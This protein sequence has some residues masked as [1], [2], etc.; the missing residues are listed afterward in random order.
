VAYGLRSVIVDAAHYVLGSRQHGDVITVEDA[1]ACPRK[2]SSFVWLLL[3]EPSHEQLAEL[4]ERFGLH[5]LAVED[6]Q[7]PHERP[8]LEQYDDF[9]YLVFCTARFDRDARDVQF[10][11]VH[12]FVAPGYVIEIRHGCATEGAKARRRLEQRPQLLKSGPAAAVWGILDE[13]VD[14]YAPVVD[15]LEAD[16]ATI[17]HQVFSGTEDPTEHIYL[18]TQEVSDFYRI[19]HPLLAPL[20]GLERG[21][22]FSQIDPALRRYYRDVNDHLKLAHDEIAGQRDQLARLLS[23]N[24]ALISQRENAIGAA[25]N[26]TMKKLTALATIFLPITWLTGFY[27]MNFAFMEEHLTSAGAF[28]A[29]SVSMLAVAVCL[30]AFFRRRGWM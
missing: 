17:E 20:D 2:G 19:M 26:A 9:Y 7:Q 24:L 12:V 3:H 15:A 16:I 22:S 5:E 29:A 21:T 10:G 8:K 28:I 27:G 13:V 25:Q 6:A 18:L 30:I 4:Q 1:A 23:A 11:E 14:G